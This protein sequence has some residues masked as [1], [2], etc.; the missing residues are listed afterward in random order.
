MR[1]ARAVARTRALP[2]MLP[3]AGLLTAAVLSALL[4]ALVG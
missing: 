1:K 2:S 3:A 4:A